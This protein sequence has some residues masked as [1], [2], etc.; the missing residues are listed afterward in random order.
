MPLSIL[1]TRET[2]VIKTDKNLVLHV[3]CILKAG[4]AEGRKVKGNYMQSKKVFTAQR[5]IKQRREIV[6][7]EKL[8]L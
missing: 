2:A 6:L 8:H 5:N 1:G 7:A 3:T 4:L